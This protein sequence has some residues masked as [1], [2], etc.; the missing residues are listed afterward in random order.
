MNDDNPFTGAHELARAHAANS[1]IYDGGDDGPE[2]WAH[3]AVLSA[4]GGPVP[5]ELLDTNVNT[6][7]LRWSDLDVPAVGLLDAMLSPPT[8]RAK[9]CDRCS[10][11]L[12]RGD[13]VHRLWV[14]CGQS[15]V[16]FQFCHWC[17]EVLNDVY[18]QGS[19]RV[20]VWI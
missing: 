8:H 9:T 13:T 6:P 20:L 5:D 14:P 2:D 16:E 3:R 18:R 1:I 7:L 15:A 4:L 17:H 11:R 19:E 12:G 10:S